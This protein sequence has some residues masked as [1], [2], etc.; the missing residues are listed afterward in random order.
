MKTMT[1]RKSWIALVALLFLFVACQGDSPTAPPTGGGG[2]GPNP[3]PQ[4][5]VSLALAAS[6]TSPL[7][8]S[9][10]VMTATVTQ[11]GQP[12]PNGTAV[13]FSTNGGG[14]DGTSTTSIIKTTTNG[15]ATVSL[16]SS[17]PRTV[18]VRA[19]INNVAQ[20]VDVTFRERPDE[21]PPPDLVPTITSVNP[22]TGRPTG[23]QTIRI[24]GT[25]FD[26]PVRVLFDTGSGTPVEAFVV[27]VTDTTI[28]VLT[29][30]VNLG[31]G[32]QLASDVIVI[33]DLGS[34]TEQRVE[35]TGAFTFR[36]EQLTPKISTVT[37][38]SGPVTGNTRVSIF[39]EGFQAPVQ[40]LF[41]TAEARVVTVQYSEI[42]VETPAGRDTSPDGSDTVTGPVD[43]TV[44]NI[45]SQTTAT[46]SGGFHYKNA[47]VITAAGPTIGPATGGTRVTIE[48]TGFLAPVAVTIGG[49]AAQPI[50]V[51]GTKI[52]AIASPAQV[53]SCGD[54]SGPISVTNINNGD[55]AVG[56]T[57]VYDVPQPVIMQVSPATVTIG[58]DSTFTVVVANA[59]PGLVRFKLGDKT[60]FPTDVDYDAATM[61]ATYTLPIPTNFEFD[62]EACTVGGVEGERQVPLEVDVNYQNVTTG[63]QDTATGALTVR[64]QNTDC[65]LPPPPDVVFIAPSAA[66]GCVTAPAVTA[67]SGTSTATI[68]FRNGGGQTLVVTPGTPSDPQFTIPGTAVSIEP[69]DS[70]SFTVTFDPAAVGPATTTIPFNTNDPDAAEAAF[71]VCVNGTGT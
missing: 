66:G 13:E 37:P 30:A 61:V 43:V 25:N 60:V 14:F 20:T 64:P 12:V 4:S 58:T 53:S 55:T 9:T 41:G 42:I 33:T 46:M 19:A 15:V 31:A 28:D 32:Q 51:T 68:T 7:V 40:V 71:N 21:E 62:T 5:T 11:N 69:N 16:T 18:R 6:N 3:P 65:V 29:P 44:R 36:N 39:G 27:A 45:N 63:C 23:G 59:L 24:N 50:Q 56:P 38:N 35:A 49:I 52:I 57:F 26:A 22:S 47:V 10:V 8:D 17:V 48:G 2:P 70:G 1:Q 67:A 54:V 34:A